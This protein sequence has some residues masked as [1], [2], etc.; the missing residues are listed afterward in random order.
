[1]EPD[2]TIIRIKG[3]NYPIQQDVQTQVQEI[4]HDNVEQ[5]NDDQP[6]E[7]DGEPHEEQENLT[8]DEQYQQVTPVEN[9]DLNENTPLLSPANSPKYG[10]RDRTTIKP[11]SYLKHYEIYL[12]T[13]AEIPMSYKECIKDPL[14]KKAILEETESIIK[15]NTWEVVNPKEAYKKEIITARWL[16]KIKDN[17]IYKARLVARGCQQKDIDYKETYSP[18]VDTS[19]LRVLLAIAASKKHGH[20]TF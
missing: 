5:N 3:I 10:L 18:V 14:W 19:N 7:P 9:Q 8:E 1:M 6:I 20:K 13:N 4:F 16:Q 11:P 2:S 15:N 12:A 17:G